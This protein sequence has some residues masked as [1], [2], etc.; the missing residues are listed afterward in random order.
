MGRLAVSPLRATRPVNIKEVWLFS[1]IPV[2]A[3]LEKKSE[4]IMEIASIALAT[5][6]VAAAKLSGWDVSDR[7]AVAILGRGT[8][9]AAPETAGRPHQP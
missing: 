4:D 1:V 9:R 8:A 6:K 7:R 3:K 2:T 5:M